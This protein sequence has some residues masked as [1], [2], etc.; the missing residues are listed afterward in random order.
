[1]PRQHDVDDDA[2]K[3]ERLQ[4]VLLL[5]RWELRA[6][7]HTARCDDFRPADIECA[8][9]ETTSVGSAARLKRKR[10]ATLGADATTASSDAAGS[11]P[12]AVHVPAKPS[13]AH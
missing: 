4:H 8:V 11:H 13:T 7:S 6:A 3:P 12:S 10:A 2:D 5:V 9:V 1:M